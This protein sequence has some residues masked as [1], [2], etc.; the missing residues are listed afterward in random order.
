MEE[1]QSLNLLEEERPLVEEEIVKRAL[2]KVVLMQ[3]VCWG[4]KSRVTWLKEGD[5][6]TSSF[7]CLANSHRSNYFISSLSIEGSDTSNQEVI[8]DSIIHITRVYLQK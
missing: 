7:H 4:Q 1:I 8:N 2:L 3:E 5:H 6:N